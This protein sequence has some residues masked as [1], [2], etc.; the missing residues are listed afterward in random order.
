MTS[1]TKYSHR[2]R[3]GN[4]KCRTRFRIK[5][6]PDSYKIK[7]KC[8]GCGGTR[9]RSIEAERKREAAKQKRCYC[10]AYP[11]PHQ[12]GSMRFC[13]EHSLADVTATPEEW[14]AYENTIRTDRSG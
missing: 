1:T 2:V 5:R 13:E 11:F 14:D 8:P 9:L 12:A 7:R 4:T 3:C 10:S 6:H